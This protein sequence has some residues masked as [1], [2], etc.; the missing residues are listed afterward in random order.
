MST[1][2]LITPAYASLDDLV[3]HDGLLSPVELEQLAVEIVECREIW[4]PLVHVDRDRRR[5]ELIYE[6]EHLDAWVLSWMPGQGTGFHDHYIS[7]V[8]LC[9]AA[10]GVR[11]DLLVY[12]GS[13]IELHLRPGDSR[14][15]GPGYIH[16]VRHELGEPAVTIHVYSPRLDWVGQ[17]RLGDNGIVRREVRPG[18]N[19]LTDQLVAEG[20][21]A[22]VLERF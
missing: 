22:R 17:Y 2:P 13:D 9:C 20:A 10:G 8:G 6:D 21:L 11:E 4:E 16:R 19:E 7:G 15:G 3:P 14:Q 1:A 5:Y 18:R 12:G